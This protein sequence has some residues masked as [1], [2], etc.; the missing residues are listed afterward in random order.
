MKNRGLNENYQSQIR[1]LKSQLKTNL[2]KM[3]TMNDLVSNQSQ[4]ETINQFL[5]PI[6]D[7][8][9]LIAK[10]RQDFV[11]IQRKADLSK[12]IKENAAIS[13]AVTNKFSK[14]G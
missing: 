14:I 8:S 6:T 13:F 5:H 7:R 3:K 9:N 12:S 1:R 10:T 2:N 11:E 4:L